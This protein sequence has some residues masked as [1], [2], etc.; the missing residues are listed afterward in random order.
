MIKLSMTNDESHQHK[1]HSDARNQQRLST[2]KLWQL[3][4]QS[5]SAPQNEP[6]LKEYNENYEATDMTFANIGN[7]NDNDLD[8]D[9]EDASIMMLVSEMEYED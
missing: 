5:I 4:L 6:I 1:T 9:A 8:Y 3:H 7:Q 2:I